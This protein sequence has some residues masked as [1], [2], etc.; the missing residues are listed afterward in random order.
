MH[1]DDV[2]KGAEELG[3]ELDDHIANVIEALRP[4]AAELGLRTAA[5][6]AEDSQLER[7]R[8]RAGRGPS[9]LVQ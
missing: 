3:V 7:G 1:R 9:S 4:I 5:D 6:A 8:S 2:Y